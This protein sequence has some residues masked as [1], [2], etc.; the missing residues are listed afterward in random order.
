[1]QNLAASTIVH[2]MADLAVNAIIHPVP[3]AM[4]ELPVSATTPD[5]QDSSPRTL[6]S[7][8]CRISPRSLT[9]HAVQEHAADQGAEMHVNSTSFR[10]Y[11]K[12]LL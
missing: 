1:M 4:K 6:S 2:A 8:P 10:F 11:F 3:H 12:K 7:M 5:V 9:T